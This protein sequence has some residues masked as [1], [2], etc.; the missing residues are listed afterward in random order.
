[1]ILVYNIGMNIHLKKILILVFA[2]VILLGI[3]L[4]RAY[5]HIYSIIGAADLKPV[6]VRETYL[7]NNMNGTATT[8]LV[9]AA[10]GDS[11]T[12][13]AGTNSYEEILPYLLSEKLTGDDKQ[14]LLNNYSV[15]GIETAG[16]ISDLLPDAIKDN[17]DIVTLLIGAN[18]IH[19]K[20]SAREF[21]KNYEEILSRLKKE[22]KAAI[23]VINI[24]FIG[25][26]KLMLPPY[27]FLFDLRTREFNG[28]IK[29]LADKYSVQYIDLYAPTVDLF[30]H[31]GDHYSKDLFH[32]SATGYKL[33]A[34]IIYDHINQ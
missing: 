13:G 17:P 28:I 34:D 4:N 7:I 32:P 11:L 15:P 8:T 16:V 22:T 31:S 26:D 14:I 33:W 19:N 2:I 27:Q 30:K 10:L 25:S 20:V 1:M 5:S 23:Y 29:N 18:D 12:A 9:Y 6:E 24:P 21:K 3:Y